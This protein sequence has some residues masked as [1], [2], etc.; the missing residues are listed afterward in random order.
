MRR[1]DK[2]AE[3]G[4]TAV[5]AASALTLIALLA[6]TLAP[7]KASADPPVTPPNAP[8]AFAGMPSP[9]A[10]PMANAAISVVQPSMTGLAPITFACQWQS[11]GNGSESNN[12]TNISG[13]NTCSSF[14]IPSSLNGYW[15]KALV[16]ATNAAGSASSETLTLRVGGQIVYNNWN[17]SY[18]D[19]ILFL[20]NSDGSNQH[21]LFAAGVAWNMA[22]PAFSPFGDEIAFTSN[23]DPA[24]ANGTKADTSIWA[25]ASDGSGTARI[26]A[27]NAGNDDNPQWSPDGSRLLY[28]DR[29]AN[30]I[31][32]VNADGTNNHQVYAFKNNLGT[33][34]QATWADTGTI[35]FFDD[36]LSTDQTKVSQYAA[37]DGFGS[38]VAC[39]QQMELY[40]VPATGGT[41]TPLTNN[42]P[43]V[44]GSDGSPWA[45]VCNQTYPS[46]SLN[47]C[48]GYTHPRMLGSGVVTFENAGCNGSSVR[49]VGAVSYP[50]APT[51]IPTPAIWGCN[52]AVAFAV[53]PDGSEMVFYNGQGFNSEVH[54][55]P[56][57]GFAET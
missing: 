4:R 50:P 21:R 3:T 55:T 7:G 44:G 53:S 6:L 1:S 46:G 41:A 36:H 39:R 48:R 26:I 22:S 9:S 23:R 31:W 30:A 47:Y 32:V 34:A 33:F 20:M 13:G 57:S 14:T 15:V 37:Y 10:P 38:S 51:E 11:G 8:P 54:K 19:P 12:W 40:S 16:T 24:V 49:T 52:R 35:V 43:V 5:G 18:A 42:E 45:S 27:D 56:I 2:R 17:G 29:S 25:I 28:I